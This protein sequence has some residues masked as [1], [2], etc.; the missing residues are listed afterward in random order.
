ME[1][2][3]I[4]EKALIVLQEL[5]KEI[6]NVKRSIQEGKIIQLKGRIKAKISDEEINSVKK[7]LFRVE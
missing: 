4:D 1:G 2:N 3:A 7:E 5:E 6:K